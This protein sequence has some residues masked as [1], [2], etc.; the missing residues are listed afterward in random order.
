MVPNE[1]SNIVKSAVEA[2]EIAK[3]PV[4][5]PP[6]KVARLDEEAES[7]EEI[8]SYSDFGTSETDELV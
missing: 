8:E 6:A 1:K 5:D 2:Y 7:E 3:S 4:D